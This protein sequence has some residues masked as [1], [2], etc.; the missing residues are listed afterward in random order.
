MV[1]VYSD[2]APTKAVSGGD[3][4]TENQSDEPVTIRLDGYMSP[5]SPEQLV[6]RADVGVEGNVVAISAARWSTPSGQPPDGWR[7]GQRLLQ[8][9]V[10]YRSVTIRVSNGLYG[11]MV[12]DVNV[13]VLGGTAG[14][15]SMSVED[16]PMPNVSVGDHVLVFLRRPTKEWRLGGQNMGLVQGYVVNQGQ[17]ATPGVA[18]ISVTALA[19]RVRSELA[20]RA[21][22]AIEPAR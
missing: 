16:F 13:A 20:R 18:P 12:G 21:A 17:A 8:P 11:E 22:G 9:E 1:R 2:P 15:V 6:Y 19:A 14:T 10:I 7:P 4:P 3:T 5:M